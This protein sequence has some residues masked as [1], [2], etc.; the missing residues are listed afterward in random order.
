MSIQARVRVRIV[1]AFVVLGLCYSVAAHA[2]PTKHERKHAA[3]RQPQS[4]TYID[5]SGPVDSSPFPAIA[6]KGK[7]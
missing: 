6:D 7:L 3:K 4:V 1:A 2:A 5:A